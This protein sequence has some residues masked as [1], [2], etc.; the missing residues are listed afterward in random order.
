MLSVVML[1]VIMLG[2]VILSVIMLGAIMLSVLA[3]QKC[4]LAFKNRTNM[5]T[6]LRIKM[7]L[8]ITIKRVLKHLHNKLIS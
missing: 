4:D 1:G 2:A 8:L 7:S 6:F 5:C 3:P